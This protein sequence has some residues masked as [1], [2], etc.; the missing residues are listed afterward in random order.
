MEGS[1]PTL[2]P[3][4]L[5]GTGRVTGGGTSTHHFASSSSQSDVLSSSNSLRNRSSR[6]IGDKDSPR[7]VLDRST[8]SSSRHS[9]SSNGSAKHPYSSFS[10]S[11]KNREKE[12]ERS[13]MKDLWDHDCSDPLGG[14]LS[15]RVENIT[16]RRSQSLVSRKPGDALPRRTVD[17]KNSGNFNKNVANGALSGSNS[18]SVSGMQKVAFEKDFPSLGAEEKPDIGRVPSPGLSSAVHSLPIGNSGL[19]GGEGWTSALAEVPAIIG[20]TSMGH[21][22]VQQ[23]VVVTPTSGVSSA[24]VG[25]NMAEALS[26]APSRARTTPQ[27]P[28]KTQWLEELAIKQSRQLIPMTPSTPKPLVSFVTGR[29]WVS[30]VAIVEIFIENQR[31]TSR[32]RSHRRLVLSSSDKV[33]Q[34]KTAIRTTES[35]VASKSGQQ[36]QPYSSQLANQSLRSGHIRNDSPKASH[37]GKFHVLKPLRENGVSSTAKD[38]PSTTNSASITALNTQLAVAAPTPAAPLTGPHYQKVPPLEKKQSLSQARSRSDFFNLMR[39]KSSGNSSAVFSTSAENSSDA[40]IKEVVS[41]PSSPRVTE[42]GV[43]MG[44][45][46]G[47]NC[48]EEES[49]VGFGDDVGHKKNPPCVNGGEVYPNEEEAAFLRSLGWDE[50]GGGEDECLTE[51]E[52]NS[53]LQEYNKLKPS[54]KV[55]RGGQLKFEMLCDSCPSSSGIASSELSLSGSKAEA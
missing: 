34:P 23:S 47:D 31:R 53:F 3:E 41:A 10:R 51:E 38:V 29:K 50:N 32:K 13:T 9:S 40:T 55:C 27:V 43:K 8:S 12:K 11:H 17:S 15:S 1:E 54:L 20:G 26:Q 36:Q 18:S 33:K 5:R 30:L 14:I 48:E 22:S 2:V 37:V 16:L 49:V 6:S 46:A 7:F 35:I 19:I 52:I 28:D 25:L 21:S 42:N 24:S 4:W 45:N 44:D 39:K